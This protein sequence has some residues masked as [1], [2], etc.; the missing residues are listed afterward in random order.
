MII[1]RT[2]AELRRALADQRRAGRTI[3]LVPTMGALHRGHGALIEQARA[4]TDLVVVSLFV[5]PTQFNDAA[6]LDAYPRDEQR[7][8][9]FARQAGVDILFAPTVGEIYPAGAATSVTVR[10]PLTE[11]LEAAHRGM[12]HFD[13]VA[14]VVAKLFNIVQPDV[15]VFG[16][17]DAQQALVIEQ[18]V[19]DLDIPVR[20][21]VA[22]TVRDPDGLA[23]SSRN[24]RL[25]QAGRERASAL[26]QV[27][28]WAAEE[29][30]AGTPARAVE[31]DAAE[32]LRDHG[33]APEYVA[34]VNPETLMPA[35]AGAGALILAAVVVDGVRLIDNIAIADEQRAADV[36]IAPTTAGVTR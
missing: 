26:P 11:T 5:N 31:A 17:K 6:D 10:G 16:R 29:L 7:D 34:V 8:A 22:P 32:R 15:A 4:T 20:I 13:G 28:A 3:G 27:L 19:R 14:T 2:I 25:D 9:E 21:A 30:R 23:L 1:V 36:A 35:R 18:L 12:A 33:L 24:A